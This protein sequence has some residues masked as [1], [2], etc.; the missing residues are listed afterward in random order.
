MALGEIRNARGERFD[1]AFAPGA[2]G[3]RG[4]V[5]IGHGVTSHKDRPWLVALGDALREA[6]IA[7]LRFSFAGNGASEGRY[8]DATIHKEVDDL[9]SVL[10]ALADLDPIY[11]GHSMGGAVGVLRA[12]LDER[13]RALVS[14]AGMVHVREF[15]QVHFGHLRPGRDVMLGKPHCPLTQAFL[16]DALAIGSVL[17]P[18]ARVRVPWLIVHGTADEI[19]PLRDSRDVHAAAGGR[20]ELLE[21]EGVDHRFTGH[22]G[23]M[24]AAVV[25]WL[26]GVLASE[27]PGT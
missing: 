8:E 12:A 26:E 16:D 23:A 19:V 6:G 2:T 20:A 11:A 10:D 1:Y 7:S 14:L 9:G 21:L 27:A 25:R 3:R 4:V 15:M 22:E 17:E 13:L 18:A 5:V 24:A